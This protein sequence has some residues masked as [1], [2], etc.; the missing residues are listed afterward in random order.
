[1]RTNTGQILYIPRV[2]QRANLQHPLMNGCIGW[3][4]LTDGVG[5]IANDISQV[6]RHMFA[7]GNPSWITTTR[8]TAVDYNGAGDYYQTTTPYYIN[9]FPWSMSCWGYYTGTGT[10]RD[11][12]FSLGCSTSD[13]PYSYIYF[14]NNFLEVR[15]AV[16]CSASGF[17]T[18]TIGSAITAGNWYH[19]VAIQYSQTL[20]KMF[21]NG[22]EI[23]SDTNNLNSGPNPALNQVQSGV[24]DRTTPINDLLGQAQNL[25]LWQRVITDSEALELYTNPWSG[26]ETTSS[27]R[28]FFLSSPSPTI[29]PFSRIITSSTILNKSGKTVIRRGA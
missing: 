20:S 10:D 15:Y 6:R 12:I 18:Q 22:V 23:G 26:L 29:N 4:P 24:L 2:G 27:T 21:V 11:T 5:S 8:G 19:I 9:T 25:R 16:R 28:Y 3:W 17:P 1:M 14:D 13:V 7:Q